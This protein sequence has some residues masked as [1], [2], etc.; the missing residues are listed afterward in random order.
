[1][2]FLQTTAH[3]K[4]LG[5]TNLD[6]LAYQI[7]R[8]F[9]K[10]P[11]FVRDWERMAQ[12]IFWCEW[13]WVVDRNNFFFCSGPSLMYAL[14]A[15]QLPL[16][17]VHANSIVSSSKFSHILTEYCCAGC[18]ILC[19]YVRFAAV[20]FRFCGAHV[21]CCRSIHRCRRKLYEINKQNWRRTNWSRKR[22]PVH[23]HTHT[24]DTPNGND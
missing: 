16:R 17:F 7:F 13:E 21:C 10:R 22:T 9:A 2:W 14:A 4:R 19:A 11:T 20:A 24:P 8:N 3:W 18:P 6:W 23:T 1:M 5:E 15:V 12:K